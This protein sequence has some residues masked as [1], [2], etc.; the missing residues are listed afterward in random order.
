MSY[1]TQIRGII[2]GNGTFSKGEEELEN[3][4]RI[5]VNTVNNK[6]TFL[7]DDVLS[8]SNYLDLLIVKKMKERERNK[9]SM[10]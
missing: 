2:V 6:G 5:L 3:L 9:K 7:D 10:G 1:I 4:R 8:L